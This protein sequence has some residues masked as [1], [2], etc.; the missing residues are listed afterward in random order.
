MTTKLNNFRKGFKVNLFE[1]KKI[2]SLSSPEV[3]YIFNKENGL[4]GVWGKEIEEDPTHSP[5]GPFIADIELST[6][7]ANG[8]RFCY[9]DNTSKGENMSFETFTK[10]FKKIPKTLTQIAFGIGDINSCPDLFPI[11][12]YCRNNDYNYVVPNITINSCTEYQASCLASICGAVAVS[13]YDYDTCYNSVKRL[14][15]AGLTQVNIHA[16][17]SE[18]TY[19]R[20][21]KVVEDVKTDPR[22]NKLNA[23]VFLMLKNKGRGETFHKISFEKYKILVNTALEKKINIGFDSCSAFSFLSVV[24]NQNKY[25]QFVE[26]CESAR[27]SLYINVK[28]EYHHCSFAEKG[29]GISILDCEDFVKDIWNHEKV[30]NFR[31]TSIENC[32]KCVSCQLFDLKLE[33]E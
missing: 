27:F 11:M 33:K 3:N 13:L 15:D 23:I 1:N 14:T 22:L 7:C 30:V 16:V 5:Y 19:D 18:E 24:D 21:M 6:I 31:N 32:K 29:D 20:C 28:G 17:V 25:K 8:C 10:L 12:N 2:K 26:E 4:M 9:K